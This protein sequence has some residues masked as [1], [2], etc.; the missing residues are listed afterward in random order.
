MTGNGI[1][2]I[3]GQPA[4]PYFGGL[5]RPAEQGQHPREELVG[6]GMPRIDFQGLPVRFDRFLS[7][8]L[9]PENAAQDHKRHGIAGIH[10]GV[11]NDGRGRLLA[12]ALPPEDFAEVAIRL[13]I[14][15]THRDHFL[16]LRAGLRETAVFFEKIAEIEMR[17]SVFGMDDGRRAKFIFGR[18]RI[19]FGCEDDAEIVVRIGKVPAQSDGATISGGGFGPLVPDLQDVAVVVPK[20]GV[21]GRELQ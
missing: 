1:F 18:G 16:I 4:P 8:I 6:V 12:P 17:L 10:P 14:V 13:R 7:A 20:I 15:G 3:A 19:P 11:L 21:L 2:R 5:G 9:I